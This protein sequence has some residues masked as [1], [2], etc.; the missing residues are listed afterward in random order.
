M[1]FSANTNYN[2]DEKEDFLN[3]TSDDLLEAVDHGILVSKLA[4][5]L[6]K[7]LGMEEDFCYTMANAGF[8]HDIGKLQISEY[9]YGRRKDALKIEELRYVRMHPVLGRNILS[10]YGYEDIILSSVYHHHE[11]YDGTGY[12][13]NLKS[14]DIPYGARILRICDVFAALVSER[15]YRGAFQV[16]MAIELMIDEIKNFDMEIFL[17]FLEMVHSEDMKEIVEHIESINRKYSYFRE[18]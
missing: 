17:S 13:D 18:D 15:R 1:N 14:G 4:Y 6:S 5:S 12:P 16:N 7:Q 8:V 3:V 9:L 2:L 10:R 11:N